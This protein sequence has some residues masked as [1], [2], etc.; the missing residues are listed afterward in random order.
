MEQATMDLRQAAKLIPCM[1]HLY[2]A[3]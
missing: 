1:E 3:I 2:K